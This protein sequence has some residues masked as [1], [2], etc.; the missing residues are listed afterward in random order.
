MTIIP[1]RAERLRFLKARQRG[2]GAT[3]M[4]KILGL[5]EYG[6]DA[7]DVY[8]QKTRDLE[9]LESTE[10]TIHQLRGHVTEPVAAELYWGF[11]HEKVGGPRREGR[12]APKEYTHPD[13][14]AFRVHC[15]YIIF[16]D[17]ER[18]EGLRGTGVLELKAPTV[19]RMENVVE[20]G[21]REAEHVQGMVETAVSRLEWVSFGFANLESRYGPIVVVDFESD[22][23]VESFLLETGQR[24]WDEHVV[25]RIPPD[26]A[27]WAALMRSDEAPEL[28]ERSGELV[29]VEEDDPRHEELARLC[30]ES[31]TGSEL[32]KEGEA[33]DRNARKQV[34]EYMEQH[35]ETDKVELPGVARPIIIRSRGRDS[36]RGDTLRSAMPIDRD[37]FLRWLVEQDIALGYGEP[38]EIADA[39]KLDLDLFVK[40]GAPFSYARV[41]DKRSTS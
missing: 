32:K 11:A 1:S 37:A 2:L 20:E 9:A 40:A 14:P 13:Y 7:L 10:A 22:P 31:M 26:P 12:K 29:V 21:M 3:D 8:F 17:E 25:P 16:A 4:P 6:E 23:G 28:V 15:D 33:L 38:D 34:Q 24:F 18:P 35:F 36:F 5:D 41:Y 19:G 39:L 30:L 27:E